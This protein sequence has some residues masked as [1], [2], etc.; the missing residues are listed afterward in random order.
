MSCE[1]LI[2]TLN[3][4]K[5]E[6]FSRHPRMQR[7]ESAGNEDWTVIGDVPSNIFRTSSCYCSRGAQGCYGPV[8]WST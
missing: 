2:V 8:T 1:V 5:K 3:N 7:P 6:R 4:N